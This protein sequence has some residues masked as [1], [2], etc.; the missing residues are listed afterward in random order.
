VSIGSDGLA[1]KNE[2]PLAQGHPHPQIFAS[3]FEFGNTP[4]RAPIRANSLPLGTNIEFTAVAVRDLAKRRAIRRKNMPPSPCVWGADTFYCSA[5]S[6]FIPGPTR[7]IY[8]SSVES[9]VRMTMWNLVDGL[10]E[11][12]LTLSNLVATNV[13]LDD[14]NDFV[15]MNLVYAQYFQGTSQLEPQRRKFRR[16]RIEDPS[17][18]IFTRY[19]SSSR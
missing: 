18:T 17:K 8:A 5:K 19:S 10:E 12:G 11:T 14:M 7:G 16:W 3:H 4:A 15:R 13:H 6:A 1:F 2:G 9:Q